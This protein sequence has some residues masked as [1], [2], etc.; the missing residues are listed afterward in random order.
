MS[1]EGM[2]GMQLSL[3][4]ELLAEAAAALYDNPELMDVD[5]LPQEIAEFEELRNTA[6]AAM[7]D[8]YPS[9]S[10]DDRLSV[11]AE[12]GADNYK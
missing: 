1:K 8:E 4:E 11:A 12:D 6:V 10:L 7:D 3:G 9:H 5:L 2:D